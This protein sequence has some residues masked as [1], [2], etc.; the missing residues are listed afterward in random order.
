MSAATRC[1]TASLSYPGPERR[2]EKAEEAL[3]PASAAEVVRLCRFEDVGR[4]ELQAG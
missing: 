3:A 2:T 1:L 4:A